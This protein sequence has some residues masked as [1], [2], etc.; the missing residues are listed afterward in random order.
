MK[1]RFLRHLI[2][3]ASCILMISNAG[4]NQDH[5]VPSQEILVR[6]VFETASFNIP[7]LLSIINNSASDLEICAETS[8]RMDS[9]GRT[10]V[11]SRSSTLFWPVGTYEFPQKENLETDL[12]AEIGS[13]Y[14]TLFE[15]R[16]SLFKASGMISSA[17]CEGTSLD[18]AALHSSIITTLRGYAEILRQVSTERYASMIQFIADSP[19]IDLSKV[20]S[21]FDSNEIN[22]LIKD[23]E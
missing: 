3:A 7:I 10:L 17:F 14:T 21:R 1:I 8:R 19:N 4:A 20:L 15:L 22:A 13:N 2:V 11:T 18:R 12:S 5:Q 23:L 9:A 16:S 6:G